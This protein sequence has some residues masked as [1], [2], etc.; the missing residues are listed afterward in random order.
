MNSPTRVQVR[1]FRPQDRD[2]VIALVLGI[3]NGEFKLGL[4][5]EDQPDLLDIPGQFQRAGGGFWV[6]VE[7]GDVVV[8]CI[9]LLRKNA[10]C[11]VLRS[12]FVAP[13]WRGAASGCAAALYAQ[14]LDCAHEAGIRHIL[15]DTPAVATR[16]Q[17]FYQ[18]AGFV[19]VTRDQLPVPH[20]YPD[21]DSL[22]FLLTLGG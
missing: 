9:G 19:Q 10:H 12:F 1:E 4:G 5:I 6:A 3:Q 20:D 15:L 13:A 16:A 2:A 17:Q 18:R 14:L 8:G 21:R 7:P 11:A 22:L